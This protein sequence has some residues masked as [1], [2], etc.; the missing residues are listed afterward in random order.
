MG[1]KVSL[2]ARLLGA[3]GG[4]GSGHLLKMTRINYSYDL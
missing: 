4:R 1:D 2:H 3:Y